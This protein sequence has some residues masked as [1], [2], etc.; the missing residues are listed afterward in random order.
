MHCFSF[1]P[2]FLIG[3]VAGATVFAET[4][5]SE[6]PNR[7]GDSQI[8]MA[9]ENNWRKT[10]TVSDYSAFIQ[11]RLHH[12]FSEMVV[13]HTAS[14]QTVVRIVIGPDGRITELH[15]VVSSGDRIFDEA[16]IK[17]VTIASR[18]F[19]PPPG[20]VPFEQSFRLKR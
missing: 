20:G 12:A 16:A 18:S 9:G 7:G 5:G 1:V 15:V 4:P 17:A 6:K 3:L 10:E 13:S 2:L 19:M 14:R 8:E 11:S